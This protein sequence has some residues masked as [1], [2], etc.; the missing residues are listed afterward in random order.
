LFSLRE[1]ITATKPSP[2]ITTEAIP[3]KRLSGGAPVLGRAES[4]VVGDEG[5][6]VGGE[7]EAGAETVRV[8]G[9]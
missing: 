6:G 1:A 4:D 2:T 3:M 5:A 9:A 7:V 8:P